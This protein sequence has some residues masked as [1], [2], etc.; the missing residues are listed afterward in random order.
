VS[1]VSLGKEK[2]MCNCKEEQGKGATISSGVS[3]QLQT[4]IKRVGLQ[5]YLRKVKS[6]ARKALAQMPDEEEI[7]K[8]DIVSKRYVEQVGALTERGLKAT[9][10]GEEELIQFAQEL[11]WAQLTTSIASTIIAKDNDGGGGGSGKTCV[12]KCA[13]EYNQCTAE[14]GCDTGGW[15]CICCSPCSLQ[16][17]GCVARC[18]TFSGGIFGGGAVIL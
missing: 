9:E 7:S 11:A 16:Y 14:N 2:I 13:D 15:I 8:L 17:M 4:E 12:T 3:S 6:A 5:L 1:I 18:V 10:W